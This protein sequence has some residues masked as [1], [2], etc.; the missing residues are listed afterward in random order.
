MSRRFRFTAGIVGLLAALGIFIAPLASAD[1]VTDK[2]PQKGA[3]A[4][5][6]SKVDSTEPTAVKVQFTWNGEASKLQSLTLRQ[7]GTQVER[8][9]PQLV[10]DTDSRRA[11]VFVLDQSGSMV[12]SGGLRVAVTK[13]KEMMAAAP[14]NDQFGIITFGSEA[15]VSQ[16]MTADRAVLTKSLDKIKPDPLAHTAMWDGVVSGM[17]ILN[18]LPDYEHHLLLVTDG[19][20]DSSKASAAQARGDV[21]GSGGNSGATVFAI[22]I[23]GDNQLDQVGLS[24]LVE[25]A[26]GRLFVTKDAKN[27][28][29]AFD[30][31]NT[32]LQNEY[33][34]TF[35]TLPDT[36]GSNTLGVTIGNYS[37]Q[38][39]FTV[40]GVQT[41]AASL[42]PQIVPGPG[43]PAFFRT[44]GGLALAL[45]LAAVAVGLAAFVGFQL[46]MTRTSALDAALN[47][48]V[49]GYSG[50]ADDEEASGISQ[51]A[52]LQRAV[53][54]TEGFAERQGFLDTIEKKLEM[55]EIPLKAAEVLLIWAGGL[56]LAAIV[57]FIL[58]GIIVAV[59][60]IVIG[61]MFGPAFLDMRARMRQRK[62][63]TQLPDMLTLLAGALRAGFSLMQAVDAVSQ[64]VQDPMGK[65]LRRVVSES[66]L[67]RD[68]EDALD[69]TAARTGSEDFAWAVM[70]IRIQR[71]VG[72]N[73]AE[74]LLTVADT[75]VQR[76]RLRR[77]VKALTAE[78]RIS[79][80][81]LSILP[82]GLGVVMYISNR[83][84]M[85]PLFHDVLGQVLL[86]LSAIGMVVGFLWMRKV[87][88][89]DV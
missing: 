61:I 62:F 67:G 6:V 78:G 28:A 39:N 34:V 33:V 43:G 86:G 81:V 55:A 4:L 68:L 79:A 30:E 5:Q 46:V 82:P 72:G 42:Q 83:E 26:G 12:T 20:D 41:G 8:S 2:T 44:T 58:G 70:A 89:I 16:P 37:T 18:G 56:L 14:A 54:M 75:M 40:G 10:S 49:E 32:A 19:T 1:T 35:P 77:E 69:D 15:V 87:V 76:E 22:G 48:Y 45:L 7:N 73:L 9:A 3:N 13:I 59:V 36:R 11:T 29:N 88:Q 24:R 47:P 53:A 50:S 65:E 31:V 27:V 57:G 64:E 74:L 66:R 71:E 23:T 21:I 17:A 25:S 85:S 60:L 80:I 84:Y 51:N 52:L 38:V 63:E